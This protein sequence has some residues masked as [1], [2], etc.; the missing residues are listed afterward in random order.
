MVSTISLLLREISC[1]PNFARGERDLDADAALLLAW[2]EPVQLKLITP[3]AHTNPTLVDQLLIW[4][5]VGN[6]R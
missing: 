5:Q 4:V 2:I 6:P 1:T 3:P